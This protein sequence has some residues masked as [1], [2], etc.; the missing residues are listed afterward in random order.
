MTEPGP[1]PGA[2]WMSVRRNL[3][4]HHVLEHAVEAAEDG[5]LVHLLRDPFQCLEL[6]S[7]ALAR[8]ATHSS[9]QRSGLLAKQR[10]HSARTQCHDANGRSREDA[11]AFTP[12]FHRLR[13]IGD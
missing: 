12:D 8:A 10:W 9:T 2:A 11:V 3:D 4:P 6:L 5:E 13:L 1:T 7:D